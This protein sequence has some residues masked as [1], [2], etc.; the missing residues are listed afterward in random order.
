VN[1]LDDVPPEHLVPNLLLDKQRNRIMTAEALEKANRLG[2]SDKLDE[3]RAAIN[4]AI[5]RISISSSCN[6]VFSQ[7]LITDLKEALT[8]IRDTVS[9]QTSGSKYMSSHGMSHNYQRSCHSTP[10][11]SNTS[12][13][14]TMQ[15]A[16][17]QVEDFD[18]E[19]D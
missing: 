19:V 4:E 9:Y 3:A 16:T 10:M 7:D 5:Q 13:Q 18:E 11:Y 1:R 8:R 15:S 6:E 2:T 12:K 17:D 14:T